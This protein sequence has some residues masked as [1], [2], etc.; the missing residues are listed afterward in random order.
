MTVTPLEAP[1]TSKSIKN[2]LP[3]FARGE[4]LLQK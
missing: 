4:N 1:R 3:V 2:G